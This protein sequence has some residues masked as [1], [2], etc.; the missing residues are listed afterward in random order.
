MSPSREVR[1]RQTGEVLLIELEI[2]PALWLRNQAD[3]IET[4]AREHLAPERWEFVG[5]QHAAQLAPTP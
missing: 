3:E 4:V 1:N 5:A 2:G